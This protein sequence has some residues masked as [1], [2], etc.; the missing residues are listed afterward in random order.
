LRLAPWLLRMASCWSLSIWGVPRSLRHSPMRP[1]LHRATSMISRRGPTLAAARPWRT[2]RVCVWWA[3]AMGFSL[4]EGRPARAGNE[5]LKEV[6][7]NLDAIHA[8]NPVDVI[9]I[10]GDLTDAGISAEWAAFLDLIAVYPGLAQRMLLL[11]GNHDLNV[12]DRAN[13]ARLD[14]PTSPI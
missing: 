2:V 7:R 11:P 13:P 10:T 9:L 14:L 4:R 1:C 3:S 8:K 6:L 5:R 12:V